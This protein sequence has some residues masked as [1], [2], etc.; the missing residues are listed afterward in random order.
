MLIE[1]TR[2]LHTVGFHVSVRAPKGYFLTH[3]EKEFMDDA[4]FVLEL[5]G[6]VTGYDMLHL[7]SG[8]QVPFDFDPHYQGIA[9]RFTPYR[10][11]NDQVLHLAKLGWVIVDHGYR[12][13]H[14]PRDETEWLSLHGS[15]RDTLKYELGHATLR[16]NNGR[17][18]YS[19]I[20]GFWGS[21]SANG[22]KSFL[23]SGWELRVSTARV[24]RRIEA[25]TCPDCE[26]RTIR[27]TAVGSPGPPVDLIDPLGVWIVVSRSSLTRCNT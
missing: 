16:R 3:T 18:A 24:N 13:S 2:A 21:L 10:E 27:V 7:F 12:A 1:A 20:G 6:C 22:R 25:E 11:F 9:F 26:G 4:R 23:L 14:Y 5:C 8:R 19:L 17:K 15:Y